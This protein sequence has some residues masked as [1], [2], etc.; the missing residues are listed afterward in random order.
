MADWGGGSLR[1]PAHFQEKEN[2]L[3]IFGFLILSGMA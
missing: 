1:K 2:N 3:F